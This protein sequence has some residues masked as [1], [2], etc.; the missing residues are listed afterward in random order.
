MK[1]IL[2]LLL[3][4]CSVSFANEKGFAVKE[5]QPGSFYSKIGLMEGD[6]IKKINNKSIQS[7]S[8]MM[9]YMGN[10]DSVKTV[11]VVRNGKEQVI[12]F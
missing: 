2:F 11:V 9:E 4:V 8:E 7:L 5:I 12:Q 10:V 1:K 6:V 3:F